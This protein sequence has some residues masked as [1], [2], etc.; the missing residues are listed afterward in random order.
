LSARNSCSGWI[1]PTV[2]LTGSFSDKL[3]ALVHTRC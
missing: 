2:L 1:G 3:I